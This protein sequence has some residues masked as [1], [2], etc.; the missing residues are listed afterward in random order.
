MRGEVATTGAFNV[1]S[2]TLSP[3]GSISIA[4]GSSEISITDKITLGGNIALSFGLGYA[5]AVGTV[6]PIF[7]F[8]GGFGGS[9]GNIFNLELGDGDPLSVDLSSHGF[10]GTVE[11]PPPHS[12]R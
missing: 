3:A 4:L 5:P 7:T 8:A 1:N 10:S 11:A 6:V 12:P 2:L 9:F